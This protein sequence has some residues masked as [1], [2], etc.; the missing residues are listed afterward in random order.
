MRSRLI[1]TTTKIAETMNRWRKYWSVTT[2]GTTSRA[3]T[4]RTA[5]TRRP[6]FSGTLEQAFGPEQQD[7]DH[8]QEAD[9][10]LPVARHVSRT[11]RLGQPEQ[12]AAGDRADEAAE[13]AQD[14]DHERL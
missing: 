6:L 10:I 12:Q 11:E 4:A 7:E 3:S 1:A 9:R 8:G 13:A 5:A 2:S 14:H